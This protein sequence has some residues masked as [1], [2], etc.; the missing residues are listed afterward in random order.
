MTE[1]TERPLL[2]PEEFDLLDGDKKA[3]T[4]IVSNFD[5]VAGREIITQYPLTGMP[6]LGDYGENQKLMFK[7]MSFVA[8]ITPDG[9]QLRLSTPELVLNH[10]DNAE[11]LM[12][13]EMKM[14]EK[15][16]SFFKD[17]RFLDSL[18]GIVQMFA[19]KI[20]EILT[21]SSESL[22]PQEKPPSTN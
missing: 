10:I 2:K 8:V 18:D 9:R 14:M 6:K 19:K 21:Q 12:K 22:S 20:L 17:G 7:V 15:N 1:I 16:F 4:F 3:K 11:M 5:C 13:L